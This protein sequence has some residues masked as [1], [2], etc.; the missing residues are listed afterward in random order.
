MDWGLIIEN[1]VR[2]V[3]S[4]E[5]VAY[6]LAAIGI[7]VTFG[8]T[9]LLNFGQAGFMAVGAY[10]M[11]VSVEHFGW[12]MWVGIAI[13]LV[14]AVLLALLMGVPTLRLRADYLAIVTIA[15]A[16]I[17]RLCVRS[18]TFG[19]LTGGSSGVNDFA[20]DFYDL[21]PFG[22]GR[23]GIGRYDYDERT[24]WV[25]V[26]GWTL[27]GLVSALLWLLMRSPW[28]RVIKAIRENEDAVRSLGKNVFAYKMQSLVL[29]GVIGAF[30]GIM[31]AIAR[32]S[33]Q[34][35][36]YSRDITFLCLTAVVLGGAARVQGPIVGAMLL[37]GLLQFSDVALRQA[38]SAGLISDS[39]LETNQTGVVRFMLVGTILAVL[40]VFRPQGIFGDRRE[41]VFDAR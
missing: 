38:K 10:G 27:I 29:S 33:V 28:G 41:L 36:N 11:A 18:V 40:M 14:L 5:V 17:I 25:I 22:R 26:V 24:F 8:Y 13:G 2:A 15:A 32:Q 35:D 4:P 31:L 3:F 12:S 39:I 19:G 30:G 21:N 34:P 37:W 7:N 9:G 1:V 20:D 6:G 23:Y 16:E